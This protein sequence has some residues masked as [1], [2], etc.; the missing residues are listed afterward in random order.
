MVSQPALR[1]KNMAHGFKL[2]LFPYL[3]RIRYT[4][5]RGTIK[6]YEEERHMARFLK[7]IVIGAALGLLFAP[8]PGKELRGELKQRFN[9]SKDNAMNQAKDYK[10]VAVH[11]GSNVQQSTMDAA[12][13]IK[14]TL[15]ET[16]KDMKNQM[17]E[18]SSEVK[19]EAQNV[20]SQAKS[21]AEDAQQKVS[22]SSDHSEES[23]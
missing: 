22:N 13:N 16:A 1:P 9:Q 6:L 17:Q 12:E 10:D 19:K 3:F 14:V 15:K 23:D 18:A 7:G 20:Q 5:H 4:T 11:A 2:F 8:K 21:E